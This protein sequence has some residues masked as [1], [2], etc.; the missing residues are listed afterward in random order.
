MTFVC[1]NIFLI[2]LL[3]GGCFITKIGVFMS[4][5]PE[6]VL[7]VYREQFCK[8]FVGLN[9][10]YPVALDKIGQDD[11]AFLPRHIASDKRPQNIMIGSLLSQICGYYQIK[12]END[13]IFMYQRKGKEAGLLGKF[14]IGVGGH[15]DVNDYIA[16]KQTEEYAN[17]SSVPLS[18]LIT[19]SS[20]RELDEELGIPTG[21]GPWDGVDEINFDRVISLSVDATNIIHLGLPAELKLD[22]S[23]TKISPNPDELLNWRWVSKE[24]LKT[25]V[26]E[27]EFEAWSKALIAEM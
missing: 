11:Y 18:K 5:N 20:V 13:E 14:S 2:T 22:T 15:I 27:V 10:I 23:K 6:F 25:L 19:F 16:I 17:A 26:N 7:A 1:Y 24:E 9:G 12:N 4:N 21:E 3:V 8:Q